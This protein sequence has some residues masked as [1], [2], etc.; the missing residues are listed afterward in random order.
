MLSS[1]PAPISVVCVRYEQKKTQFLAID[2]E[3][4]EDLDEILDI[5]LIFSVIRILR[6]I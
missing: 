5:H 1:S 6:H 2:V 3:F 4:A